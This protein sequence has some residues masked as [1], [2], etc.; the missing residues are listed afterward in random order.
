ML[1]PEHLL[2]RE[3]A[4]EEEGNPTTLTSLYS[5]AVARVFVSFVR[6]FSMSFLSVSLDH[7]ERSTTTNGDGVQAQR[8]ADPDLDLTEEDMI[9]TRT[10]TTGII[11]T[12]F[13]DNP[14]T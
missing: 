9:M 3:S 12:E 13:S 14:Y 6:I 7:N 4:Y 5:H 8:L 2:D 11:V 10:R 1:P